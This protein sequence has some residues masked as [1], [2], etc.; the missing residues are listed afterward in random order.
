MKNRHKIFGNPDLSFSVLSKLF[1][2]DT[3]I[4]RY[5]QLMYICINISQISTVFGIIANPSDLYGG[6]VYNQKNL[7]QTIISQC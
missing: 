6:R 2:I 4:I 5:L 1:N 7:F 3:D